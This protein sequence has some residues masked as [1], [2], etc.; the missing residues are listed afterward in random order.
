MLL[1]L[2]KLL[3]AERLSAELAAVDNEL[4]PHKLI[5]DS[6]AG[7]APWLSRA[8]IGWRL[9]AILGIRSHVL[10]RPGR[11]N[12]LSEGKLDPDDLEAIIA[13]IIDV[14]APMF[15][16]PDALRGPVHRF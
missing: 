10:R 13:A 15:A 2:G 3:S 9:H 16:P 12:A 5:L 8:E 11:L 14:A 4:T 6:L 1:H 7:H